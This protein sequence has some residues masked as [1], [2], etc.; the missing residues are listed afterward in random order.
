MSFDIVPQSDGDR[1]GGERTTG[2]MLVTTD[3][4][5]QSITASDEVHKVASLEASL[6]QILKL[7]QELGIDDD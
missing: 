6:E 5:V 7:A 3:N 1:S 4:R 2:Q